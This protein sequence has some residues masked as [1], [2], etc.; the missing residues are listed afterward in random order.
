MTCNEQG[1][2]IEQCPKACA[3]KECGPDGCG[4]TCGDCAQGWV[5]NGGGLC[6][7]APLD[8]VPN[9]GGRECGPN[10]CGGS[11]GVCGSEQ[12]CGTNGTCKEGG[13]AGEEAD[14]WS[15]QADAAWPEGPSGTGEEYAPSSPCPEGQS[16]WY[17]KC[18]PE[19]S[20][21]PGHDDAGSE[22]CAA[23]PVPGGGAACLLVCL[24]FLLAWRRISLS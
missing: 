11:C 24:L 20:I 2:C 22:G 12:V 17:G 13:E 23:Q 21:M 1:F 7:L 19:S 18:L 10:G 8:C 16:L 14:A 4:G 3:G 6:E 15:G 9:C 5:C